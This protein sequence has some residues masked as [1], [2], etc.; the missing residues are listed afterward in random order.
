MSTTSHRLSRP[1][2]FLQL[3]QHILEIL[4]HLVLLL[5]LVHERFD[6]VRLHCSIAFFLALVD[7]T[8]AIWP[9]RAHDKGV[10]ALN[11]M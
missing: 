5:D 8:A 7:D 2:F 6:L 3:L 9:T 10:G 1:T 11:Q 4:D